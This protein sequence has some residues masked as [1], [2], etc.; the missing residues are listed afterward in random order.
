ME[1]LQ[2]P[3]GSSSSESLQPSVE[4][5]SGASLENSNKEMEHTDG[6]EGEGSPAVELSGDNT[7]E[8]T[9]A[10]NRENPRM[11]KCI[12]NVDINGMNTKESAVHGKRSQSGDGH[13][14]SHEE[15]QEEVIP[16]ATQPFVVDEHQPSAEEVSSEVDLM[17]KES[18]ENLFPE[19]QAFDITVLTQRSPGDKTGEAQKNLRDKMEE[20]EVSVMFSVRFRT[21]SCI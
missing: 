2:W 11:N 8:Q 16:M 20:A 1:A 4:K 21:R 15:N 12:N 19:T 18:S 13:V 7:S 5:G 17:A 6:I 14:T 10:Q 9:E 3:P